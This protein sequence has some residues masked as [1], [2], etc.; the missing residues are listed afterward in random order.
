MEFTTRIVQLRGRAVAILLLLMAL[1]NPF[2]FSQT[3]A[4][5]VSGA[6][7][8][9]KP[10]RL[11]II[12][13]SF[14]GNATK[15][16]PALSKEGGRELVIGRAEL[17]GCSLQRHWEIVQA[18]EANPDDPK[19]KAYNG[20]SLKMLLSEGTW[21]V[22]TLQQYSMLSGDAETYQPYARKLHDYIKALQP[23]A[24]IVLHQTWAYRADADGFGKIAGETVAQTEKEMWE[25]ARAAYH[26]V[27]RELG[28]SVIPT[29]DAFWQMSSDRNWGF[30]KDDGFNVTTAQPPHL[31][32]EKHSLH[33]GYRWNDN[34]LAFDSHHANNAGCYL[35]ALVW[36]GFLF[37]ESPVRLTFVPEDVPAN[38][39]A[40]LRKT[41]WKA[42]LE[43]GS[44]VAR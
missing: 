40:Q 4:T 17:G 9:G 7:A 27:A 5:P 3:G 35:G 43:A 19:G 41:A 33:V 2:A 15:Y 13:N 23:S 11:F 18:A 30:R 29:G 1:A 20:K 36:Y 37:N 28:V 10:L 12:G 44:P 16:L 24:K 26:T 38:F 6:K 31:P 25:K 42:V 21:D 8:S 34:K 39:A 32:A 22:V 14:S